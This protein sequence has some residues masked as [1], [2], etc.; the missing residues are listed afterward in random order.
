VARTKARALPFI[1]AE[2]RPFIR[3]RT[4]GHSWH[5]VDSL[6]WTPKW[7]VPLTLRCER[8]DMERR[9]TVKWDTGEL[10]NRR[11]VKP[12][13]YYYERGTTAPTRS[14]FRRLLLE[15]R[16]VTEE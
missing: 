13:A 6:H 8:C 1:D 2:K 7:G 16:G 14:E 10:L 12:K 11:Y 4:L 3:C 5:D 9:D 15:L